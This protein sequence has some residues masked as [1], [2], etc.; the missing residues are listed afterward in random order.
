MRLAIVGTG[1]AGLGAAHKLHTN[2]DLEVFEAADWIGGHTHTVDVPF[3]DGNVPVDTG[4]IVYNNA[5][6]PLLTELF[7]ELGVVSEPSDMSFAV[8]GEPREYEGSVGGMFADRRA[9]F[10]PRHWQMIKDILTFNR[11]VRDAAEAP[12]AQLGHAR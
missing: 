12:A 5:T 10:D 9:A 1:I 7:D 11:R 2:V 3:A 6:Y 4:F 8:V